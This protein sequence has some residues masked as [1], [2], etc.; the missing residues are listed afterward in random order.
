M[1]SKLYLL[2]LFLS[3]TI[4]A[5]EIMSVKGT[6]TYKATPAWN[7][8]STNYASAGE[9]QVQIAKNE[10]GGILKLS[11]KSNN[12]QFIISGTIYVYL[13]DN[14]YIACTDK[15][16]FENSDSQLTSYFI[17]TAA[18]MNKLKKSDIE[19]IRFNIKG[20]SNHFSSPTG[21]FTAKNQKSYYSTTFEKNTNIFETAKAINAL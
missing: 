16:L 5:Q 10:N 18:E 8:I 4:S 17:F 1:K 19:S 9:I 12:P 15:G 3:I 11:A 21:N 6:K 13:S 20:K 7:F 2:F 14:S